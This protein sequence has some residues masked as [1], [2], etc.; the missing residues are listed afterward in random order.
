MMSSFLPPH[1]TS[2]LCSCHSWLVLLIHQAC[3]CLQSLPL[4]FSLSRI[5][6]TQLFSWV[7]PSHHSGSFYRCPQRHIPWPS[8]Y[9]ISFIAQNYLFYLFTCLFSCYFFPPHPEN[10]GLMRLKHRLANYDPQ[11]KSGLPPVF[12]WHTS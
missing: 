12:V 5:F 6:C 7:D 8:Y 1:F 9:L 10:I 4:P 11:A 3:A 2:L